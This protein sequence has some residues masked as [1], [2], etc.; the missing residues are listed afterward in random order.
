MQELTLNLPFPPNPGGLDA[1]LRAAFGARVLGL[2]TYGPKRPISI[3]FDDDVTEK[4]LARA[5]VIAQEHDPVFLTVD[6]PNLEADGE[7]LATVTVYV[8]HNPSGTI[9]LLV[10]GVEKS[11]QISNNEGVYQF[12]AADPQDIEISL[13]ESANRTGDIIKVRAF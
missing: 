8:P 1:A 2:S 7:T 9:T 3:W 13:K 4:E 5:E 12:V 11:V 10:N 6:T